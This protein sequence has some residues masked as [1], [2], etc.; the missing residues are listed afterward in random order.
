MAIVLD[1]KPFP[2]PLLSS[3]AV[4]RLLNLEDLFAQNDR[5]HEVASELCHIYAVRPG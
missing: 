1:G 4:A 2:H 5:S 3:Q